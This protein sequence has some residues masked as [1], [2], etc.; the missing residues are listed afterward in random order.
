MRKTPR[1]SMFLTQTAPLNQE[2]TLPKTLLTLL[3]LAGSAA[4]TFTIVYF[5]TIAPTSPSTT[6]PLR[7]SAPH[8]PEPQS[9]Y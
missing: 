6:P 3:W 5:C 7:P 8:M 9:D 1:I 4:L 2:I